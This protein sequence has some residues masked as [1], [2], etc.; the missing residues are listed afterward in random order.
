MKKARSQTNCGPP[1]MTCTVSTQ[2]AMKVK[3]LNTTLSSI[4]Q[5]RCPN[6][7]STR[8]PASGIPRTKSSVS[9]SVFLEF[10]QVADVEAVEALADLEEEHAEDQHADQHVERDP[11]LDHH[12]HAIRSAR[13]REE[14]SVL[15]RQE[16]D[17]LRDR[18][19]S[20][21]HHQ[22]RQHDAGHC[23]AQRRAR[24]GACQLRN[25]QREIERK[26]DED[27]RSEEHTSE[28]QSHSE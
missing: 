1:A 17:H 19:P 13:C 12:R 5:L 21:D 4:A 23:D 2:A 25:R 26:D 10:F 9:N 3:K 22:K 11:E 6:A 14:Q 28:L 18:L 8:L 7:A 15:H 20:R 24:H 16:A 27:D